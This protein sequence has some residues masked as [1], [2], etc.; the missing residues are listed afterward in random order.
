MFKIVW[1]ELYLNLQKTIY[2]HIVFCWQ[3]LWCR[4]YVF[5]WMVMMGSWCGGYDGECDFYVLGDNI[6]HVQTTTA[7]YIPVKHINRFTA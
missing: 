5:L 4:S 7:N 6:L 2:S 3:L 1:L